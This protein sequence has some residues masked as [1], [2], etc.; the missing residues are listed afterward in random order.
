VLLAEPEATADRRA[1]LMIE[2]KYKH[3]GGPA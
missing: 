2:A 1:E 3:S